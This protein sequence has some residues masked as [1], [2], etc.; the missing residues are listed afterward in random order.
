MA[1]VGKWETCGAGAKTFAYYISTS[2]LAI[3]VGQI[4]VNLIR[5]GQGAQLGLELVDPS[6]EKLGL[7]D[8][9]RRMVPENIPAAMTDNGMMLQI[10]FFALP[11]YFLTQVGEPHGPR[12]RGFIDGFFAVMLRMAEGVCSC[13]RWACSRCSCAWRGRLSSSS[14]S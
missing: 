6:T 2:L 5:P 11:G 10:I 7:V 14:R 3:L 9:L 1:G 4:L 8:I 13:Y 12:V